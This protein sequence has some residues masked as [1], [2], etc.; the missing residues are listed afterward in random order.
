MADNVFDILI[1]YGL[2]STKAKEAAQEL[3][4]IKEATTATGK[5]GVKQEE[6]VT[7]ATKK[8]FTSK[9]EL[10]EMVKQLGMEFPILGQLGRLALN[11]IVLATTAVTGAFQLWKLRT[12]EVTK[13]LGGV[14]LPDITE[15]YVSRIERAAAAM[16]KMGDGAAR[17]KESLSDAQK[18]IDANAEFYKALGADLGTGPAEAKAAEASAAAAALTQSGAAKLAAAGAFNPANNQTEAM[19]TMAAA[20]AAQIPGVLARMT[21]INELRTKSNLN[22]AKMWGDM[23]FGIRYGGTRDYDEGLAMEQARLDSLRDTVARYD[24]ISRNRATRGRLFNEGNAD[25]AAAEEITSANVDLRRSIGNQKAGDLNAA[26]LAIATSDP[27]LVAN[28]IAKWA[29][30]NKATLEAV[31]RANQESENLARVRANRQ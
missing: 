13:S 12:D 21:E 16:K 5:E 27:M 22:P 23:K 24:N 28:A 15:D 31:E 17:I 7:A 10:K 3:D 9:K 4:K 29:A 14:E 6:A 2:D 30:T 19:A 1:K 20:A 18:A 8:T 26:L 25:L 11:P